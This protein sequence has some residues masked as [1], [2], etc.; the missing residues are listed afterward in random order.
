[1]GDI[2]PQSCILYWYEKDDGEVSNID[3]QQSC[4]WLGAAVRDFIAIGDQAMLT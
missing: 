3:T 2:D 1:M 4:A